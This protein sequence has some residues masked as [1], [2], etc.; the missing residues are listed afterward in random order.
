MAGAR[1]RG[2]PRWPDRRHRR[3]PVAGQR[4]RNAIATDP[5]DPDIVYA[6][7]AQGGLWKTKKAR[8]AK[9]D[10]EPL[11]DHEASLAVGAV[12]IDP[13]NPD[14]IYVG[15]GEANRSCDSYYGQG[16]LRSADGGK[17]WTLL[18]GGGNPFGNPGP[19]VGKAISKILIDPSTAGSTTSDDPL[20]RHDHRRLLRRDDS[21]VRNAERPEHRPVAI[22]RQRA[23]LAAAGDADGI[24]PCRTRRSIR[25]TP[26]SSTPP[27]AAPASSSR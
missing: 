13:V 17:R 9:P 2:D 12:A 27:C 25:T 15:T 26:T 18:G 3:P 1:A 21:D 10:W 4:P 14:I 19:F 24:S 20:G 6:G 5:S 8:R 22:D 11:T 7:G 16:I 23:D